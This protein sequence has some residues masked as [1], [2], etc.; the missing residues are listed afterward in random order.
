MKLNIKGS[1]AKR[2]LEELFDAIV[3]LEMERELPAIPEKIL[4]YARKMVGASAGSLYLLEDGTLKLKVCQND[5]VDV[6][7]V[8]DASN[9]KGSKL[10]LDHT[11][12]AGYS[13]VSGE[14]VHVPDVTR[15]SAD[16]PYKFNSEIDKNSG[17]I[18]KSILAVP[19]RH[20]S[21]GVIGTLE[22]FNPAHGVFEN[23]N[24]GVLKS[25]SV[26]AAVTMVNIRLYDSIRDSYLETVFRLGI[27]AEF[28][29]DN[30]YGHLQRIRHT[31]KIIA[32][33]L[34]C[35]EKEQDSIFH[36]SSM[37]DIGKIGIPDSVLN[38][39]DELNDDEWA[40]MRKHPEMGAKV[41]ENTKSEILQASEQIARYHHE[42]W[43]GKGYPEG[44]VGE[45]IPQFARIVAVADVFD[46][47]VQSR[48]YKSAWKVQKA[49]DFIQGQRGEHFDPEAVDAFFKGIEEI[50]EVQKKFGE[51]HY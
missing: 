26:L 34:G 31:S 45:Q 7:S 24:I 23:W 39:K 3:D 47:L 33:H 51:L 16:L 6:H 19:I 25:F 30:T 38:K 40:I 44:L 50:L 22:L 35:S 37:H 2:V 21:E 13:V 10:S 12:I 4:F 49:L 1:A 46:A 28:K 42:K 27:V 48:A 17:F 11:S 15:I 8:I 32:R 29:D 20:P 18:S 41:L 36:A 9:M 14:A 5:E 43:N